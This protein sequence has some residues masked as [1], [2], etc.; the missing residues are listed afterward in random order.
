MSKNSTKQSVECFKD[1]LH[2]TESKRKT[3][4]KSNK[5]K[6]KTIVKYHPSLE[7]NGE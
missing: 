2:F 4:H 5:T 6:T 1:W 7:Y 3:N